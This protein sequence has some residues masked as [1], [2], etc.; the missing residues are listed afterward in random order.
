M[1][2]MSALRM[3][4]RFDDMWKIM[5]M[6]GAPRY[7]DISAIFRTD[8]EQ[9]AEVRWGV[10]ANVAGPLPL[11]D[12]GLQEIRIQPIVILHDRVD[13]VETQIDVEV[14]NPIDESS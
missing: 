6:V 11:A 10:Y 12:T 13:D 7:L 4:A 2:F 8:T 9:R 14:I 5:G 1:R 3:E